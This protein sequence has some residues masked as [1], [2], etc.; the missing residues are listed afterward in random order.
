MIRSRKRT[1]RTTARRA[2]F[3]LAELSIVVLIIGIL[4]AVSVPQI[5]ESAYYFQ[6]E[7]A[8]MRIKMDIEMARRHA[9]RTST[10]Q[11]V[12]FDVSTNSYELTGIADLNRSS[13]DYTVFLQR[14]PNNA[15]VYD[16]NFSGFSDFT[17]NG[18]GQPSSGGAV[19]VESG[20]YTRT[21]LLDAAS[22]KVT[23]QE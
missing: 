23:V 11:P 16:A 17:F 10:A 15:T 6:A 12:V 5:L 13:Q 20:G 19:I 8:A 3:T 7:A 14:A 9:R 1:N 18:F 4:S 21:I 2:G 22:G